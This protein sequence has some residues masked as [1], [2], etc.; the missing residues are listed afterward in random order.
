MQGHTYGRRLLNF[1]H[2]HQ[3]FPSHR[4][5]APAARRSTAGAALPRRVGR[6]LALAAIMLVGGLALQLAAVAALEHLVP[7]VLR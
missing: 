4:P 2:A 1:Q 6:R 5:A 7:A 3:I